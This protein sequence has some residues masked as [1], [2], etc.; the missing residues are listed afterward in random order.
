M[1][2][3]V[4]GTPQQ[5]TTVRSTFLPDHDTIVAGDEHYE[6]KEIDLPYV[7]CSGGLWCLTR[8]ACRTGRTAVALLSGGAHL[9]GVSLLTV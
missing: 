8:H 4:C 3:L 6:T 5:F 7:G 2:Q 1:A 9:P